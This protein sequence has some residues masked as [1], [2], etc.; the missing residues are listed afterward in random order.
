[1]EALE[2]ATLA[3]FD[4]DDPYTLIDGAPDA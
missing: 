4:I 2:T 1:M 3:G